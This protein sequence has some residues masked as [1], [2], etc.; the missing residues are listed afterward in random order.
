M[1]DGGW[2]AYQPRFR[3]AFFAPLSHITL[4]ALM[5]ADQGSD[6]E[7]C[8]RQAAVKSRRP[9][10]GCSAAWGAAGSG[11]GSSSNTEASSS[12]L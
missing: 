9:A 5:Q 12:T 6:E 2:L 7:V 4:H 11:R 8:C 1:T 10:R 3:H